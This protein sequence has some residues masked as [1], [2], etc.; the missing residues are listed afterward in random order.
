MAVD[1]LIHIPLKLK[2]N[3][4][5]SEI[6]WLSSEIKLTYW[7]SQDIIYVA[8]RLCNHCNKYQKRYGVRYLVIWLIHTLI[9]IRG[10][11]RKTFQLVIVKR[12]LRAI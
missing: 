1:R 4:Y 2:P 9:L 3:I 5:N 11:I 6:K 10:I 7:T 8:N 12:K